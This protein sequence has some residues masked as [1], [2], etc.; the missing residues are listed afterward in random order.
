MPKPPHHP[1][2]DELRTLF[3]AS[4]ICPECGAQLCRSSELFWSCP[5]LHGK[6]IPAERGEIGHRR[7][8]AELAEFRRRAD[9]AFSTGKGP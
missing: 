1:L 7:L 4:R 6:L 5:N 3:I 8:K 9:Q 2:A